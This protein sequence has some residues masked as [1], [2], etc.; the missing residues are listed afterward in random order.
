LNPFRADPLWKGNPAVI[1][2]GGPSVTLADIRLIGMA[3]AR[4]AIRVIAVN[5]AVYPCWFADI[6]YACDAKWWNSPWHVGVP[7]FPGLKIRMRVISDKSGKDINA[8]KYPDIAFMDASKGGTF[9][10]DPTKL[11]TGNNSGFQALHIAIHLAANP[12]ILVGF[13]MKPEPHWFGAHPEGVAN[14]GYP[15]FSYMLQ[16]FD[17][18]RPEL[19]SRGTVVLNAT[20]KSAITAFKRVSL[21]EQLRKHGGLP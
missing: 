1:V 5:D 15:D 16:H 19:Q 4:D 14:A 8:V 17:N 20:P 6:A 10:H 13:D 9:D 3:R 7:G 2:A 21:E 18:L 11:Y 12:I